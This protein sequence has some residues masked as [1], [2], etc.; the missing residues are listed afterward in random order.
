MLIKI[1]DEHLKKIII[2]AIIAIAILFGF[3]ITLE[4][5]ITKLEQQHQT[6]KLHSAFLKAN[7]GKE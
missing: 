6:K 4:Q 2:P 5:R 1:P 3:F 7:E